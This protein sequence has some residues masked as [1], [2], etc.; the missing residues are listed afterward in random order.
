[1]EFDGFGVM[2]ACVGDAF[3]KFE[4]STVGALVGW[5]LGISV[6]DTFGGFDGESVGDGVGKSEAGLVGD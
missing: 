2:G 1:M 4:G 6:G 5:K 3:G